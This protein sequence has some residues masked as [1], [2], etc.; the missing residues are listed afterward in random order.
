M[1]NRASN[2]CASASDALALQKVLRLFGSCGG[3]GIRTLE[4]FK[5]LRL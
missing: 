1:L 4:G 2:P 3:G 5:A